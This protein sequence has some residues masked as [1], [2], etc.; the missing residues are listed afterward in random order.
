MNR[1]SW[2]AEPRWR[3]ALFLAVAA[4]LNFADRAAMSAVLPAL[5]TDLK[6]SDVQLGLIGSVFLWCYALGSPFAGNLADR[7]SRVKIVTGSILAWSFV[8]ATIGL[9]SGW[10]MLL[11]L[12]AALGC[13]E[14]LYIPAAIALLADYHGTATRARAISCLTVGVNFG[15]V[16]GGTFAGFLADRLGWRAGF[17]VLGIGG[18]LLALLA[19]PMLPVPPVQRAA[20]PKASFI[21]AMKYLMRVPT[22][23]ALLLESMLS[24][25]GIWIFLNW[26]PL[27]LR[28]TYQMTLGAAGF[29][30]TF[31]LQG[32]VVL[33]LMTGGWLSD[34]AARRG[35]HRRMLAYGTCYLFAAPFLLLFLTR[36]NFA[37]VAFT[38]SAFS[39]L[40][41]V[42]AA[43]DTPT[44]CEI[45]PAQFRSTGIGLMNT[46][47]TAAGGMGVFF[48]GVLKSEFG[49]NAIFATIAGAF[50][51]AGVILLVT[52]RLFIRRDIARAQAF[53]SAPPRELALASS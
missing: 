31:M 36:P 40:R 49:L 2:L 38:V 37:V 28:E 11:A 30:G 19:R 16:L 33:G 15:V 3:A 44:Q 18:I 27:Y 5:R 22:Y 50:A 43:N 8:T 39:F 1:F 35:A 41:S 48:A 10:P 29:A 20:S 23:H 24:G 6:L 51:L 25:L 17:W 34:R 42:G 21:G 14:C 12:R 13:A 26:L 45:V 47:A 46:C 4:A 53:E 52:Y 32:A 9:T 7:T